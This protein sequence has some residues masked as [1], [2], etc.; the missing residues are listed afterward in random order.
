MVMV[1]TAALRQ[2]VFPSVVS[3]L[4]KLLLPK[5]RRAMMLS[6]TLIGQNNV[7][8][9]L[10][11]VSSE[12]AQIQLGLRLQNLPKKSDFMRMLPP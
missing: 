10:L 9:L 8:E 5:L 1:L 11:V 12:S 7:S 6:S 3:L 4:Q 2:L